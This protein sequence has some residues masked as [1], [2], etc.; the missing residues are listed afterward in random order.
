MYTDIDDED[1]S[2]NCCLLNCRRSCPETDVVSISELEACN[3]KITKQSTF[4]EP[5][6][7]IKNKSKFIM[8]MF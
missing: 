1:I 4:I 5:K 8:K 2:S 7:T 6:P 3:N